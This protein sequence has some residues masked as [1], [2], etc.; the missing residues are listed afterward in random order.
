VTYIIPLSFGDELGMGLF[1][2][3]AKV[4]AEVDTQTGDLKK[5]NTPWYIQNFGFLF[6]K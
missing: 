6:S 3:R 4:N 5:L 1:K 2:V